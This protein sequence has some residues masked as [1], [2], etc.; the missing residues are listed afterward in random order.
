MKTDKQDFVSGCWMGG[1]GM[2]GRGYVVNFH[3]A[4]IRIATGTTTQGRLGTTRRLNTSFAMSKTSFLLVVVEMDEKV[5]DSY[6]PEFDR[7]QK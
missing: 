1:I 2:I 7:L 4:I 5:V 6:C 3:H